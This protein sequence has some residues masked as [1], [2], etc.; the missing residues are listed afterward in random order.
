MSSVPSPLTPSDC[1]RRAFLRRA[2][3][4]TAGLAALPVVDA[5]GEAPSAPRA[6]SA[7]AATFR[8]DGDVVVVHVARIPALATVGGAALLDAVRVLVVR[9]A[10]SRFRALSAECPH[11]GCLVSGVEPD[12]FRCPCHGS[13]F[14]RDGRLLGGPADRPLPELR[15][16]Y[17]AE[18]DELRIVTG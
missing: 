12:A 6:P 4:A 17:D 14:A 9:E 3:L 13:R 15:A 1:S 2:S 10:P 7:P 5:C 11:A 8:R 16:T 18:G